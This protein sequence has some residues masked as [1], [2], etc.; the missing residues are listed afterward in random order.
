[1]QASQSKRRKTEEEL[2]DKYRIAVASTD[3][4]SVNQHF[5]RADKFFIYTIDD[6][7]GYD[8]V[9]TR[10]LV[11]VCLGKSHKIPEMERRVG[12]LAD[13]KYVAAAKIGPGAESALEQAGITAMELPGEIEEAV[14]KIWKFNR[15]QKLYQ[16][17]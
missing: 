14:L 11:P 17:I 4:E 7:V 13:C 12:Q 10:A 6:D 5:G 9:E 8:F 16:K 1:M 3:G 2:A 15:M